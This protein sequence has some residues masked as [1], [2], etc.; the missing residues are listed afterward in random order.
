MDE[1]PNANPVTDA[2]K[3]MGSRGGKGRARNLTKK[4]LSDIGYLGGKASARSKKR[5]KQAAKKTNQNGG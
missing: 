3:I 5:K 4:E 2:A 1:T